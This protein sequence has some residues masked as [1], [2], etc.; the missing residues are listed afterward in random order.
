MG[1]KRLRLDTVPPREVDSMATSLACPRD[2]H[3][4]R[5]GNGSTNPLSRVPKCLG[6]PVAPRGKVAW[7]TEVAPPPRGNAIVDFAI[8]A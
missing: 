2:H 3:H 1:T 7:I 5:Q 8:I 4:I 6:Q